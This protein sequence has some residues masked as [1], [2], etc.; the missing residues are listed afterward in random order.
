MAQQAESGPMNIN[1]GH[2]DTHVAIT[3]N[4]RTD[5]VFFTPAEAQSMIAGIQSSLEKLA[6]HQAKKASPAN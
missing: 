1:H 5:H 2:T 6:E 4:R 3:F